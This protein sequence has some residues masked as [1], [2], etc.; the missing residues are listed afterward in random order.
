MDNTFNNN[1]NAKCW[2]GWGAPG[3]LLIC[4]WE[5]KM[6]QLL[7]R[8]VWQF[9]VRLNIHLLCEP[10]ILLLYIYHR[11][12]KFS[13]DAKS[14]PLINLGFIDNC[15]K[16]EETK[17]SFNAWMLIHMVHPCH[18]ALI[19]IGLLSKEQTTNT[20]ENLEECIMRHEGTQTQKPILYDFIYMTVWKRQK[21]WGS[22][23]I[24]S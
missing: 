18:R 4:W 1:D 15:W 11:E 21:Y 19:S 6:I 2:W 22:E 5:F 16:L 13:V 12:R 7:W 10:L 24:S 14:F 9:L 17:I 8:M 20:C 23:Q 3:T